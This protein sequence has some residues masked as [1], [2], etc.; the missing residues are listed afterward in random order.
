MNISFCGSV[1]GASCGGEWAA[2]RTDMIVGLVD[3]ADRRRKLRWE[4]RAPLG[5]CEVAA[6]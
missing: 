3:V 4:E 2:G 1:F 5:I 6:R